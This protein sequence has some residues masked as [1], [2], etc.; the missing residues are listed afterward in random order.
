[1][2]AAGC[3]KEQPDES[4][5]RDDQDPQGSPMPAGQAQP[6]AFTPAIPDP[7][8]DPEARPRSASSRRTSS[9]SVPCPSR[10]VDADSIQPRSGSGFHTPDLGPE[11]GVPDHI[12]VGEHAI[13]HQTSRIPSI[14]DEVYDRFPPHR[15]LIMVALLSFW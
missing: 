11:V 5:L 12:S 7:T 4:L 8:H 9:D 15:K 3:S 6:S 1:M 14:P 13:T 2:P 10:D